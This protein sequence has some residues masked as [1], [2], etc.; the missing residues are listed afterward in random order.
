MLALPLPGE[1]VAGVVAFYAIVHFSPPQLRRAL[2]EMHRVLNPGGR[3]LIS[4]HVGDQVRRVEDFLGKGVSLDFTFFAPETITAELKQTGFEV[5][6]VVEREPYPGVEYP[7]RR[8]YVFARKPGVVTTDP[9]TC[10]IRTVSGRRTCGSG[11]GA[12]QRRVVVLIDA[13][14]PPG[15]GLQRR[16][17]QRGRQPPAGSY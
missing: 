14:R 6:E 10:N 4:F 7:S 2:A 15:E 13:S 5:I 1:S 12:P 3:M 16:N 8:A 17:E 11:T 9:A